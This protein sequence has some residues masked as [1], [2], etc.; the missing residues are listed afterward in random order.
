MSTGC[1]SAPRITLDRRFG[2]PDKKVTPLPPPPPPAQVAP[3]TNTI[4]VSARSLQ[5]DAVLCRRSAIYPASEGILTA[6]VSV[7]VD[8]A[9]IGPL[10]LPYV[11]QQWVNGVAEVF[12]G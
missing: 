4:E 11:V 6:S 5:T 1:A 10:E 2:I 12:R 7:L 8:E 3:T 9:K